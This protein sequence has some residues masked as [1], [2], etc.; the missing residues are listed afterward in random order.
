MAARRLIQD[1][2]ENSDYISD[3]IK[4]K[5]CNLALKYGIASKYTSFIG[6]DKKTR[7][8]VLEPAMSSRQIQQEVPRG[9]GG[10]YGPM[11]GAGVAPITPLAC[12]SAAPAAKRGVMRMRLNSNKKAMLKSAMLMPPP[13]PMPMASGFSF[14]AAANSSGPL[15]S[16]LKKP[17]RSEISKVYDC[18]VEEE[19]EEQ[20]DMN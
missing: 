13:P 15:R 9:F 3:E 1:L 2:E 4:E 19:E 7:K 17:N 5:I 11:V 14:G 6:V 20:Y 18:D 12:F 8:S 10:G 16:S